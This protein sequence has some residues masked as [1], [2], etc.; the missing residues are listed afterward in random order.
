MD[1]VS[2]ISILI[3]INGTCDE[4]KYFCGKKSNKSGF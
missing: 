3:L 2:S 4:E 1:K